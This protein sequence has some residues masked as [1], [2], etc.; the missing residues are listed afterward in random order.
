MPSFLAT[1]ASLLCCMEP[2]V[3]GVT[4]PQRGAWRLSQ[5]QTGAVM[6]KP[7]S[8]ASSLEPT[9]SYI[10]T[11]RVPLQGQAETG[12]Q[13]GMTSLSGFFPCPVLRLTCPSCFL[14]RTRKQK[15][16][17]R[18]GESLVPIIPGTVQYT[19]EVLLL[20]CP[21]PFQS[22]FLFINQFR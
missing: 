15:L 22:S 19:S 6:W 7:S 3:P 21:V 12:T 4:F 14:Q 18:S 8:R 20:R 9:L 1:W 16:R 13:F 10:L 17:Q 5:W 2:G 11:L